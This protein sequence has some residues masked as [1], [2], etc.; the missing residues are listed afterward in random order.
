M[1]I[2]K[3]NKTHFK[4]SLLVGMGGQLMLSSMWVVSV[5]VCVYWDEDFAGLY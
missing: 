2:T 5:C 1:R 4:F 3:Q